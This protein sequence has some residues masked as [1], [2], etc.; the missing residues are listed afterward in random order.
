MK[1]VGNVATNLVKRV[2]IRVT[3]SAFVSLFCGEE[4]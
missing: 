2:C 3:Q 1:V 4:D